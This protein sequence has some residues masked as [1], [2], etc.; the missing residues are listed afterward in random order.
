M[1]PESTAC[2]NCGTE[3]AYP[4]Q[5]VCYLC[6]E[7]LP[8]LVA[9]QPEPRPALPAAEAG[10]IVRGAGMSP[11]FRFALVLALAAAIGAFGFLLVHTD[12]TVRP[13]NTGGGITFVPGTLRCSE[14]GDLSVSIRLPSS[15]KA[16][17]QVTIRS[18]SME[19]TLASSQGTTVTAR[20]FHRQTNGTWRYA[21][22]L[23]SSFVSSMCSPTGLFSP[24]IHTWRVLDTNHYVLADGLLTVKP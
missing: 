24:G 10:T 4:T 5:K 18:D 14:H 9:A 6:R 13:G 23:S 16:D 8:S 19:V 11:V 20:G 7:P 3:R 17:D 21:S 15:V 2:A 12:A 22:A 1:S